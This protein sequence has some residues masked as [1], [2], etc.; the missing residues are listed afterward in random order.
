MSLLRLPDV[1]L[2]SVLMSC[3]L[4][5]MPPHAPPRLP[6]D[7]TVTFC[8]PPADLYVSLYGPSTLM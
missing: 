5:W 7:Y 8:W 3:P 2:Y 1:R 4:L 6:P